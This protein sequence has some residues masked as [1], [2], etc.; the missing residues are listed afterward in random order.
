MTSVGLIIDMQADF[1]RHA[2]LHERRAALVANT[3]ALTAILRA[4]DVPV[5]WV[6]QSSRPT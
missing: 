6:R 1:F 2:R 5:I 4:A 3:N